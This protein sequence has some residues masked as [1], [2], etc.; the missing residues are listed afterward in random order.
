M[1]SHLATG[2]SISRLAD[3]LRQVGL[4]IMGV[5]TTVFLGVLTI[6]GVAGAVTQGIAFRTAK[7]ATQTFVPVVAAFSPMPWKPWPGPRSS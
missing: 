6:Q 4:G 2:F 7:Y 5:L 1:I 3:F